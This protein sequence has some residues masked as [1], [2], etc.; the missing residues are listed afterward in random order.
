MASF[1]PYKSEYLGAQH[2][3]IM[4]PKKKQEPSIP[5]SDC[6]LHSISSFGTQFSRYYGSDFTALNKLLDIFSAQISLTVHDFHDF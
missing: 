6:G 5:I 1:L 4:T 3:E 2:I